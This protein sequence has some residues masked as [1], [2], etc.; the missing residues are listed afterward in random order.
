[1]FVF[2]FIPQTAFHLDHVMQDLGEWPSQVIVDGENCNLSAAISSVGLEKESV[3]REQDA[4]VKQ[5]ASV[6]QN[7]SVQ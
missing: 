4:I 5:N 2:T 7:T 3:T 6:K 1:M